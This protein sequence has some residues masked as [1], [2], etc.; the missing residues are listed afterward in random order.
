LTISDIR[1]GLAGNE[2]F[3]VFQP[4][5]TIKSRENAGGRGP[6]ALA[7]PAVRLVSPLAFIGVAEE[8]ETIDL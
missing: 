8:S 7:S 2:L 5:V 4:K 3:V 6:G 1:R